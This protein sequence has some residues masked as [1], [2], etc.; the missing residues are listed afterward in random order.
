M[1]NS[2]KK[3]REYVFVILLAAISGS[4]IGEVLARNI[5]IFSFL[6]NSYAIGLSKPILLDLKVIG[7]TFGIYFNVNLMSIICVILAIILFRKY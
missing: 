2:E 1:K 4:F 3:T 6:G 5:G 7:I